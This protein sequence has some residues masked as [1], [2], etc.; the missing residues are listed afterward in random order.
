MVYLNKVTVNGIDRTPESD[1]LLS[2]WNEWLSLRKE[3]L[4]LWYE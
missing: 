2:L 1:I 4:N 3:G